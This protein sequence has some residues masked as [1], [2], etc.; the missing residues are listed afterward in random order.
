[1]GRFHDSA[2]SF[3][4]S[5]SA[6]RAIDASLIGYILNATATSDAPY[7]TVYIC[8]HFA[9]DAKGPLRRS[10][11]IEPLEYARN[12]IGEIDDRIACHPN[13]VLPVPVEDVAGNFCVGGLLYSESIAPIAAERIAND[14]SGRGAHYGDSVFPVVLHHIRAGDRVAHAHHS[15]VHRRTAKHEDPIETIFLDGVIDDPPKAV[16][17]NFNTAVPG[18]PDSVVVNN[19]TRASVDCDPEEAPGY[20]EAFDR[21]LPA[22][23]LNRGLARIRR[24]N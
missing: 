13:P 18:V 2:V 6:S 24:M 3:F 20:G 9:Q 10:R 23:D 8:A 21:D 4:R 17:R 15:Y 11:G 7:G 22:Q 5:L 16:L 1:M 19:G 12:G 14:P